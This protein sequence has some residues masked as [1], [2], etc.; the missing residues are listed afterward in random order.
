MLISPAYAQAAAGGGESGLVTLLPLV[1]IFVVFYF[2]LIR[3]QQKKVKQHKAMVGA[4]RRGDKVVTAGGLFATVTKVVD[5]TELQVELAE[6]V[7]V[8]VVRG[9]ISEVLSRTEPGQ[10]KSKAGGAKPANDAGKA[11]G[12]GRPLAGATGMLSKLLG[13]GKK[14]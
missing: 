6:G 5:E 4:V 13:V 2:L 10:A 8:R 14:D 11:S 12:E 7:R 3:P 1:L 9:T